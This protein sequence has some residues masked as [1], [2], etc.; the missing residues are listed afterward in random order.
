MVGRRAEEGPYFSYFVGDP[1]EFLIPSDTLGGWVR[2]QRLRR[3][4]AQ[5][6]LAESLHVH[7]FTV[8]RYE[9]NSSKPDSNVRL[10][11]K[12]IFGAGFER[13]YEARPKD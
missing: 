10:R 7:P 11:L 9:R 4:M 13:F 5:K 8:V 6:Q 1:Y 2:N 3:G 12:K